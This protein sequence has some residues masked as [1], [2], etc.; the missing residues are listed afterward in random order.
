MG[1]RII[2]Q[3]RGKGSHT[4][5]VPNNAF[6]PNIQYKKQPGVV[7]DILSDPL[8]NAPLAKVAYSD[9]QKG[10]IVAIEGMRVGDRTDNLVVPLSTL[11]EGQQIS[12]VETY[13]NS[14]PKLC[15]SPGSF[16]VV[17]TKTDK[18]IVIILPSKKKMRLNAQCLATLGIPAGDGRNE[19][20]WV[21]AG[22]KWTA[23]HARGKLYPR[24]SGTSMNAVDHPFG[25]GYTGLGK[26]KS[27]SRNAPPGRKV[28][29]IASR[30]TGRKNR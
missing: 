19:K 16:A 18:E 9:N 27:V 21:K 5:R 22:K 2:S 15:R 3:R 4:Y 25:G 1:K 30:R 29:S 7:V 6:K 8:R 20:P 13:P 23:M 12:S 10:F 14:G 17:E 26:P 24:T 11:T 28:G